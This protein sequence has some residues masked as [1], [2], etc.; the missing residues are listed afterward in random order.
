MGCGVSPTGLGVGGSE[1]KILKLLL[2]HSPGLTDLADLGQKLH[3]FRVFEGFGQDYLGI[4]LFN[5]LLLSI[6]LVGGFAGDHFV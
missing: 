3:Y 1:V 4:E 6:D 2:G 5:Q